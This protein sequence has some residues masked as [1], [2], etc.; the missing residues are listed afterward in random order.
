MA[1]PQV[2]STTPVGVLPLNS[3]ALTA[4][5]LADITTMGQLAATTH[6][7][8]CKLPNVGKRIATHIMSAMAGV[9]VVEPATD[10]AAVRLDLN[11]AHRQIKHLYDKLEHVD[12]RL[13]KLDTGR[14]THRGLINSL[15]TQVTAM[16]A[17]VSDATKNVHR[18]FDRL[19][20]VE[21][22]ANKLA[23]T[24][25]I[26]SARRTLRTDPD[27]RSLPDAGE[28]REL[29]EQLEDTKN[30]LRDALERLG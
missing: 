11:G 19:L 29:R 8:L 6:S 24:V 18:I 10:D 13:E 26:E 22:T 28:A 27:L 20:V 1:K 14:V 4:L 5:L 3:R 17:K 25:A 7:E 30:V 2:L 15:N 23:G 9:N 21:E 16:E 12:E